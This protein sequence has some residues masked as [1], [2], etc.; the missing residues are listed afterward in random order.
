MVKRKIIEDQELHKKK[1]ALAVMIFINTQLTSTGLC[2]YYEKLH[3][4]LQLTRL[5]PS[6][7]LRIVP[8][9][10]TWR[11]YKFIYLNGRARVI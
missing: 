8:P 5:K 1:A 9:G 3:V 10:V 6:S 4:N 2:I 11:N 7:N